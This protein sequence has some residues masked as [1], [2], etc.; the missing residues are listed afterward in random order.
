MAIAGITLGWVG[1]GTL[2]LFLLFALS[3]AGL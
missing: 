2:A 1:V 3:I